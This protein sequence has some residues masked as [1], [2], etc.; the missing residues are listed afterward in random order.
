ME[1]QI[2]SR[3]L[4][5]IFFFSKLITKYVESSRAIS[6]RQSSHLF[7][8]TFKFLNIGNLAEIKR[9]TLH[10]QTSYLEEKMS[11]A[12]VYPASVNRETHFLSLPFLKRRC[13]RFCGNLR[14]LY[15]SLLNNLLSISLPSRSY[16]IP[17]LS[18]SFQ[19]S[20]HYCPTS[21]T[22]RS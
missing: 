7:R 6:F 20:A 19:S 5:S 21:P 1:S 22:P 14:Q 12:L 10:F 15:I 18:I 11:V 16:L 3:Q 17:C 4:S 2:Y 13:A 8:A 9:V